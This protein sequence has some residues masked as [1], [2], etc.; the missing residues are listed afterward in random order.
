[1]NVYWDRV[2][3]AGNQYYLAKTDKGL[4]V[5][6]LAGEDESYFSERV[7]QK[8]PGAVLIHDPQR[9]ASETQQ[10]REYF[11]GK[12]FEFDVEFDLRGTEFQVAVWK[13]LYDIPYGETRSYLDIATAIGRPKAVRA[14]GGACGANPVS[15]IIP[16]HRVV[17]KSGAM[18]GFSAAGGI[19][20]KKNM[21][22]FEAGH[23]ALL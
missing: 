21:L 9:L 2:E 17:G 15:L 5:T 11:A 4:L 10:V 18:T 16:C 6:T 8:E 14:V 23:A 1:M 13:A 12:R 22:A 3:N 7:R 19:E 20:S